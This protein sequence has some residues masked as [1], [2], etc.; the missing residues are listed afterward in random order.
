MDAQLT[1]LWNNVLLDLKNKVSEAHYLGLFKQTFLLSLD[2]SV[3]TIAA[4]SP[5]FLNML[6]QRFSAD[7]K[8]SLDKLTGKN[9]STLFI[10]KALPAEHKKAQHAGP[11]FSQEVDTSHMSTSNTSIVG[12]LPRVRSDFTFSN[13]A[14]SSSNQLA[15]V[16]AS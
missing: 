2:G 11:L 10:V 6:Q 14:V 3:A 16:S 8:H 5:I 7:I 13:F 9:I 1:S 4:P 15:F 12:H